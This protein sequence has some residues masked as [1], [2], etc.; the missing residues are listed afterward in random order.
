M[1]DLLFELRCEELPP[2]DLADAAA[3]L[4]EALTAAL[5]AASLPCESTSLAWTP[6]RIAVW[7]RGLRDRTSDQEQRL[8]GPKLKAAFDVEGRPTKAAEGFAKKAGVAV[9]DLQRDAE[10][11]FAIRRTSGRAAAEIVA[12]V[13]PKLPA[14]VRWKKTMRWGGP[15]A[16]AR[17]IRGVVALLGGD[18]VACDVAGL[19]AGRVT[20]GHPFLAT[21]ATR[22]V[23][24]DTA[25]REEYLAKLRKAFVLADPGE[26]RDAVLASARKLVPGLAV[27][28]ELLEEVTNLV[29]W[30][31]CLVGAFDERF[32]DLPPKLLVT[33]MEH[34]QRYFPVRDAR[35]GLESRFVAT[36]DREADS[37]ETARPGFQRV[38][39][40]RLH[41]AAFF[42]AEDRRT[43]LAARRAKLADITY[44]RKLGTLRDK[45]ERLTALALEIGALL[46]LDTPG[47][48][49][50]RE[51]AS[52][53]KLDLATLLV[54]EFPELQG[55]VGAVYARADGNPEPVCEAIEKQYVHDFEGVS[56]G[57][58]AL[59]LVLAE[60]LDV[61]CQFGTKVGLPAGGNDPFG[62]RRAAIT[63]LDACLRF[64]PAFDVIAGIERGGG[65]ATIVEYVDTRLRQRLRDDGFRHDHVDAVVAWRSV[66]EFRARL[67][68]LRTLAAD[69]SFNRLL[70]VAE[71][72]RNITKKADAS[73]SDIRPQLLVETAE[74]ALFSSWSKA[75]GTLPAAPKPPSRADV[76]R[77][78]AALAEP[79]HEFF[80]KV[81]V[82]ADDPA[83]RANRLA[84]LRDIDG[85]LLRF[86]DLCRIQKA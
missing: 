10:A 23:A 34:H 20:R 57:G 21:E 39:L 64:A 28:A 61:L 52:L 1:A 26:R 78:A 6:R 19:A 32:R 76:A 44:H 51:A 5:G 72:C 85:T 18:V 68:D 38:L 84:L 35:G 69:A 49:D 79:L 56:L 27:R 45:T 46:G 12:E 13:L 30:P 59:A 43:P 40:P 83:V 53:A 77:V 24:L 54:G 82:N 58:P 2:R 15:V 22:H 62:V 47:K 81:F 7:A 65:D 29:E 55:Y 60:N 75:R 66:G 42:V 41:D 16:F 8:V 71:R 48:G 31:T 37:I 70:E 36:M 17:P 73:P 4:A 74:K 63:L 25:S 33:V 80:A 9:E 11:V 86:A 14:Q 3:S 67:E 50:A